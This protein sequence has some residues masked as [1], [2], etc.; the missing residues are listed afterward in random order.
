M[1]CQ[2]QLGKYAC[3]SNLTDKD[4]LVALRVHIDSSGKKKDHI[5]TVAVFAGYDEIWSEFE[6]GWNAILAGNDPVASYVHM[7]EIRQLEKEFHWRLGWNQHKAFSLVTKCLVYMSRMAKDRIRMFY[8]SIDLVAWR[9]LESEGYDLVDPIELCNEFCMGVVLKWYIDK[10]PDDSMVYL[11]PN[12]PDSV[13]YFFDRGEEFAE[14]FKKH[15]SKGKD[16]FEETGK[17]NGWTLI[18]EV[19]E[20]DMK[21]V[22]GVQAADILAWSVNREATAEPG[23]PGTLLARIIKQVIPHTHLTW[24]EESLRKHFD[25]RGPVT[26]A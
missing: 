18:D 23:V 1:V 19:S 7:N 10:Y 12:S 11:G 3:R 22:P 2:S 20:V 5:M 8:C 6:S 4:I 9:K 25:L 13:H 14:P 15:W 17:A 16:A 24:D 26:A 21:K